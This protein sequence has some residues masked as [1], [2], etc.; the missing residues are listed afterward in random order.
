TAQANAV[1]KAPVAG[2]VSYQ[3]DGLEKILT[4]NNYDQLD[5]SKLPNQ[6]RD[7][8]PSLANH[9]DRGQ[10]VA[11]I[12]NNLVPMKL[13]ITLPEPDIDISIGDALKFKI[14]DESL[15]LIQGKVIAVEGNLNS[16]GVL[17]TLDSFVEEFLNVRQLDLELVLEH[18]SG[19][20]VEKEALLYE[21]NEPGLM[22]AN[23]DNTYKWQPVEI[24]GQID[25][26]VA[27]SGLAKN[28]KYISNPR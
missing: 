2:L 12:I 3:I 5:W 11:K 17:L 6:E 27:I 7:L 15:E 9:F 26:K 10:P 19:L 1:I 24:I 4:I 21:N 8:V 16:R 22:I 28:T 14:G 23:R 25:N 18:Y 13:Y 20:I